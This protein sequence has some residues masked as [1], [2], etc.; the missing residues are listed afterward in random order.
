MYVGDGTIPRH[1]V[2]VVGSTDSG[3]LVYEPGGGGVVE[4]SERDFVSGDTSVLGW[5]R[6]WAVVAP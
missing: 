1:V 3:L 5:E 2:F 6:P 4:I